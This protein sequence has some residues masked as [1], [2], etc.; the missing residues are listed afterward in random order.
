MLLTKRLILAIACFSTTPPN[1]PSSDV[2]EN[3]FSALLLV[4]LVRFKNFNLCAIYVF[5]VWSFDA[6]GSIKEAHGLYPLNLSPPKLDCLESL[7]GFLID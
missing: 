2:L 6:D 4:C 3:P 7:L 5:L 1:K